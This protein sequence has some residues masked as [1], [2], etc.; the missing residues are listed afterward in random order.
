[1]I[2]ESTGK[3]LSTVV[4]Q[5]QEPNYFTLVQ[6]TIWL[7]LVAW[8]SYWEVRFKDGIGLTGFSSLYW[9]LEASTTTPTSL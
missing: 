2:L 8:S 5:K 6:V 3:D 7:G 1:M 4:K 9:K